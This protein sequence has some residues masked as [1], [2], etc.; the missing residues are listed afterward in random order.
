[1]P[2]RGS[3]SGALLQL[4]VSA[5]LA[6]LA[7]ILEKQIESEVF[8]NWWDTPLHSWRYLFWLKSSKAKLFFVLETLCVFTSLCMRAVR[9]CHHVGESWT[10]LSCFVSVYS[11]WREYKWKT[12]KVLIQNSSCWSAESWFLTLYYD[13]SHYNLTGLEGS[14]RTV[15]R[16][17]HLV[18]IS[19]D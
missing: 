14:H 11:H 1:M 7:P 4:C 19:Q 16:I 8:Q 10:L 18:W 3:W 13:V 15:N 17:T 9:L 6:A 5:G 12:V 2:N